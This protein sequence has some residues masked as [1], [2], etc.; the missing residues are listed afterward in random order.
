MHAHPVR[1]REAA[2][3]VTHLAEAI[4]S[5]TVSHQDRQ[6]IDTAAF[7]SFLA[8]HAALT[9]NVYRFHGMTLDIED[10][11][12]IHGTNERIPIDG[13]ERGVEV[14]RE[15]VARVGAR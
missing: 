9:P 6:Q 2:P 14:L 15:L 4:R 7:D 12:G 10:A 3:A 8:F 1:A 11:A 5:P 13:V